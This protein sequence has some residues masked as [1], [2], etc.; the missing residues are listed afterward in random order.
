MVSGTLVSQLLGGCE[1][2]S[3]SLLA[4][5][6]E[7]LKGNRSGRKA[8]EIVRLNQSDLKAG[9]LVLLPQARVA[10]TLLLPAHAVFIIPEW[11]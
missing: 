2:K 1:G 11:K 7:L 8:S 3:D 4:P 10:E 6:V 5:R 9:V